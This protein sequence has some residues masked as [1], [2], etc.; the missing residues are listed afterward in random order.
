MEVDKFISSSVSYFL[1]DEI[2]EGEIIDYFEK[3][4]IAP[5]CYMDFYKTIFRKL[6]PRVSFKVL[7][8][9]QN[10]SKYYDRMGI[11]ELIDHACMNFFFFENCTI[12]NEEICKH[13]KRLMRVKLTYNDI[14][15][16]FLA[17]IN[18]LQSKKI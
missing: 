7:E 14:T 10:T 16:E 18:D 12:T 6:I 2:T 3:V 17:L 11:K 4:E 9:F 8:I 13:N 1:R 5:K 15:K